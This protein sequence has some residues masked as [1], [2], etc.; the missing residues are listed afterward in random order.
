MST[1]FIVNLAD[2]T[3]ILEQIK[4]AERN[5][6]GEDLVDIIGPDS[7]LLPMGLRTVDGSYN[8]L[9]PGQSQT[10]AADEI[11]P[12]L[13][14]PVYINDADGDAMPLGPPGAPV[15]TNT[16]YDPTITTSSNQPGVNVHSV[17]DADPR[18]ISNL[19]VDQTLTNRSALVAALMVAGAADAAR[20]GRR[21]PAGPRCRRRG[22]SVRRRNGRRLWRRCD[23]RGHRP[24]PTRKCTDEPHRASG[25]CCV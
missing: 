22:G 13:L 6:A 2:L 20:H 3:K 19:I 10:G 14:T 7:T 24:G 12:R 25:R 4:I 15:V 17:A 21:D 11:F 5:A 23:R 18:I 8:H 16:N 9:L 1:S